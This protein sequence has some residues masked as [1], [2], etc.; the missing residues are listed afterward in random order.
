MHTC[1]LNCKPLSGL[2]K[3]PFPLHPGSSHHYQEYKTCHFG[4]DCFS[5]GQVCIR[6]CWYHYTWINKTVTSKRGHMA[7][8]LPRVGENKLGVHHWGCSDQAEHCLTVI[9][10]FSVTRAVILSDAQLC[11]VK[12]GYTC[13][14][15]AKHRQFMFTRS[16]VD[17]LSGS[18]WSVR[19]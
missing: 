12:N 19:Q 6:W 7:A 16:C 3:L 15:L 2:L 4:K 18:R 8:S 1:I 11:R 5:V 14:C 10:R 9:N 17:I 13:I